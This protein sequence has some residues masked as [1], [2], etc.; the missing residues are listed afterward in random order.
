MRELE[1]GDE[2]TKSNDQGDA[3]VIDLENSD[4]AKG[5]SHGDLAPEQKLLSS[6]VGERNW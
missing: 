6:E 1:A 5:Q 2:N 4:Y 3:H